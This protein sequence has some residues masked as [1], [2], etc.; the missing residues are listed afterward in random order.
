MGIDSSL[1]LFM[2]NENATNYA[3][4]K[5]SISRFVW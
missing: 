2:E 5:A 1:V 4:A 3:D